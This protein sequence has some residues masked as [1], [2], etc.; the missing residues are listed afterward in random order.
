VLPSG[1]GNES[2]HPNVHD[3]AGP[4]AARKQAAESGSSAVSQFLN[5]PIRVDKMT[6]PNI[7]HGLPAILLVLILYPAFALQAV[8][9]AATTY[10]VGDKIECQVTGKWQPGTIVT[11]QPGGSGELFYLVNQEGE[12]HTW[13]R[14]A[15]SSQ[16][17]ALTG[18]SSPTVTAQNEL[19]ALVALKAPKAGSLDATFQ[20]LIRERYEAQESK[21]IPVTVVFQGMVIGQTHP[22]ARADV[23]GESSDGPG[24]TESTSVYPVS[25]Q[26]T[27]RKAY[28]D[29]FLTYQYDEHYSCFKNSFG[30]WE[31][32][33]NSGGKGMVKQFREER[34]G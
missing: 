9:Q 14:W 1:A 17:R 15:S 20:S 13:D 12:A 27:V 3:F 18:L 19:A 26:Y 29:A 11:V 30:K 25:S 33:P 24:G 10:K 31:C 4:A 16:I 23:Y 28:G 8:A 22:Y 6:K 32:N 21:E 5:R 34:A 2:A 7:L